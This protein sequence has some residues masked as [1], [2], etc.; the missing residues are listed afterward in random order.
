[1]KQSNEPNLEAVRKYARNLNQEEPRDPEVEL[2]GFP[3]A[4]RCL[5]KCRATLLGIQA[6]FQYNCPMDQRFLS[7]AGLDAEEFKSF[8][9]TGASD[10]DVEQWISQRAKPA[11]RNR[12]MAH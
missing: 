8:V 7:A 11:R 10:E 5:D 9:A 1:M 3:L 2:A 12:A 4:A 6:D